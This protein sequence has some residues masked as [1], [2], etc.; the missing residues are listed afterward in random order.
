MQFI[1]LHE[2]KLIIFWSPKCGCTSLKTIISVYLNI[3]DS[4]KYKHIHK[5]E[6]L[7]KLIDV[8][9]YKSE[10]YKDYDIVM[11]IR[12]PYTRLV[13]GFIN[14]Y[15]S[16]KYKKPDNFDSFLD[17]C[18]ILSK[19][20]YKIDKHHFEKQTTNKGWEFYL[21]LGKPKIKYV[22]DTSKVNDLKKILDLDI[23]DIKINKTNKIVEEDNINLWSKSY[24]SLKK[25]TNYNYSNFYN[26]YLKKLVYN[27][28]KDD[29]IF[30]KEN[31]G[32]DYDIN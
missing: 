3:Y 21:E 2:K 20:P 31:L 8:K 10:I 17:F 29:F 11:L 18:N 13:S 15:I 28:Y 9:K 14:K 23:D 30:F 7:K 12:N 16:G 32:I 25:I 24:N 27:I 4:N 19:Y 26:D 22:L 1:I 6:E 5:N